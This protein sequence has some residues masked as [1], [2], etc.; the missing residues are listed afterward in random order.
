MGVFTLG[1]HVGNPEMMESVPVVFRTVFADGNLNIG[2]KMYPKGNLCAVERWLLDDGNGPF[3]L[4]E[5][6]LISGIA[7]EVAFHHGLRISKVFFLYKHGCRS[8]GEVLLLKGVQGI[9]GMY[10]HMVFPFVDLGTEFEDFGGGS[11][12]IYDRHACCYFS[13]QGAKLRIIFDLSKS[14]A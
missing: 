1:V 4:D 6:R 3:L 11:V 5:K 9:G 10:H 7:H 8:Y 2:K 13:N 12:V 14:Y